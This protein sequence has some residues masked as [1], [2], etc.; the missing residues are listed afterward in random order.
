MDFMGC[1][2]MSMPKQAMLQKKNFYRLN[3][4]QIKASE[5]VN[6]QNGNTSMPLFLQTWCKYCALK[7][8][9]INCVYRMT[10]ANFIREGKDLCK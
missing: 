3:H 9:D 5:P 4:T 10:Q 8:K 6:K 2:S 7:C 1:H